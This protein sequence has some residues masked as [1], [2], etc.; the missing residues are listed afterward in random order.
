MDT[1]RNF[2]SKSFIEQVE[3]LQD[4]EINKIDAAIPGL[5]EL[6]KK[7]NPSDQAAFI[8]ENTLRSLL[9]ENEAQTVTCLGS[10]HL[11][12]KKIGLQVCCRKKCPSA[13]P[14][15]I[16]LFSDL[17]LEHFSQLTSG[18]RDYKQGLDILSAIALI[19]PPEALGMFRQYMDHPDSLI[20]SLCIEAVGKYKDA[21]SVDVLCEIVAQSEADD[22]YEECDLTVASAIDALVMINT[23][24]AI[25]FLAS[26]IHHRNPVARRLIHEVFPALGR[27]TIRF[28]VPFLSQDN[29]DMKIMAISLLGA[30]GDE[31]G[32]DVILDAFGKGRCDHPNVRFAAYEAF[33]KIS[34]EKSLSRLSEG[35][36]EH[37]PFILT[38]VVTSLDHQISL[39]VVK[40]IQDI[41]GKE[42]EHASRLMQ[43]VVTSRALSLF[44]AVY[45]DEQVGGK[46]VEEIIKSN[47]KRLYS[48][49]FKKL[50]SMDGK[51]AGQDA[52]KIRLTAAGRLKKKV[53][54][55]DDSKSIL[56][57]Y[58]GVAS[59]MGLLAI[60]AENGRQAL[61]ILEKD[62]SFD[63]IL[64]DI[65]MPV[66]TGIELTR[67]VR[68]D[69]SINK[70]PIVVATTESEQS[71][72]Q[73]AKKAGADDFIKKP[74][75]AEQ[76]Q[77][78]IKT[79][80]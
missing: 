28:I 27:E 67:K 55:V 24:Q 48:S 73:L 52:D 41:I 10:D 50:K 29:T 63:L 39:D 38:A 13:A 21:D 75:T 40:K 60:T 32:A 34:T 78:K 37:D 70:I 25:S 16:K 9:L 72:E 43:A 49:F 68:A 77:E 45:G 59:G 65:N 4:I 71:Q 19:Q 5:V 69:V 20:A 12:I 66:M 61:D 47:D 58:R 33:G 8:A 64:T 46:M 1:L 53:L 22:H 18:H 2:A 76:L 79:I 42:D 51:R 3:L 30:I 31:Q 80:I 6:C 11:N 17:G 35:L 7:R 14:V 36:L 62:K 74:F 54:A 26:K 23:D 44:E 56:A 57:F 15:L